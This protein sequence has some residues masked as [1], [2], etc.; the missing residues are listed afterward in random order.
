MKDTKLLFFR[1]LDELLLKESRTVKT[2][3]FSKFLQTEVFLHSVFIC[4]IETVFFIGSVRNL[5]IHDLLGL[6]GLKAFDYWRILNS[7][8]KFDMHMPK[9]LNSHFRD[10]EIRIV[11]EQ[12]WQEGSPVVAIIRDLCSHQ[13]SE[14]L[15]ESSIMQP[16]NNFFKR[17]L[18]LSA[19]KIT[20]ISRQLNANEDII[21][22]I[23]LIMKIQLSTE[24]QLLIDRHLDQLVMCTI[25]GVCKVQP[26]LSIT[27]NNIINVYQDIYKL[28]RNL[29]DIYL[30]VLIK[31]GE[32]KDIIHFY[33][34][35]Y[36][37]IMKEYII[38]TKDEEDK[39]KAKK[40]VL[41][42]GSRTPVVPKMTMLTPGIQ[43]RQIKALC[44]ES[45]I[46]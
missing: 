7:F 16:Y 9:N 18:H 21:E 10:I 42:A 40:D 32:K 22:R 30:K 31:S 11:S 1:I 12:A 15:Q 27:F 45:P 41:M 44:P 8:L 39:E 46:T 25:Y 13:Q 35:V 20:D 33:N 4:A 17:V 28:Q 5:Q 38:Q 36:I 37:K 6:V 24:P 43:K 26:S 23:W 3:D 34:D 29:N 19:Q 2:Q 14:N